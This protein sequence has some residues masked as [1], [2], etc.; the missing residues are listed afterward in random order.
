MLFNKDIDLS[1]RFI[2]ATL[3]ACCLIGTAMADS[4]RASPSITLEIIVKFSDDSDTGRRVDRI[5]REHPEDLSGLTDLPGQLRRSTGFVLTPERVTSGRE[6]IIRVPEKP[7]LETVKQT[8]TKRQEV[9]AAK[10]LATQDENPRLP[11]SLLLLHFR[12][13]GGEAELLKKAY[14]AKAYQGRVQALATEL[15]AP[16]GVPVRGT[17][18][19]GSGLAVTVDRS[20]LLEEVVARLNDLDDV[21]YAQPN[22][23]VQFM[24]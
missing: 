3:L 14:G 11:E 8:V 7:L 24:K 22:S 5:L 23:T 20:A 2:G 16:S 15:C 17:A 12:E 1:S 21:D 19:T 6:L 4:A 18:E 9:S 13:S 10:I